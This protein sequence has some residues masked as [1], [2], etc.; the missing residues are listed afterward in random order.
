[1]NSYSYSYEITIQ[2]DCVHIAF[3]TTF[4]ER[5]NLHPR[6]TKVLCSGKLQ[7]SVCK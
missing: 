1:M 4:L 3:S 6:K 2:A 5:K 7:G